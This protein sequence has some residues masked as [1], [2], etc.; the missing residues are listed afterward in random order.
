MKWP[1]LTLIAFLVILGCSPYSGMTGGKTKAEETTVNVI[2]RDEA[3]G[4]LPCFKC[5]SYQKFSAPPKQGIFAH[6]LHVDTGYHC[7]QCHN[8]IGHQHL[9]VRRDICNTCHMLKVITFNKTALP[10]TF[11]HEI[12]ALQYNCSK[13]HPWIFLMSRGSVR[14]TM[15]DI[16]NGEFCGACHDGK[17]AFS[18]S[19][20]GRCHQMQSFKNELTYKVDIGNVAFSHLFHTA[21]FSCDNCHPGL[22]SMQKTAGRMTMDDMN[23]GKFCGSCHDGNVASSVADCEKCHKAA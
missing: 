3:V 9:T 21:A 17:E 12:H 23:G 6:Q 22:F 1:A 10:S 20:C 16:S 5:H 15:K 4:E 18:S 14:V 11:D 19:E 7:N 2:S 8:V 13:C